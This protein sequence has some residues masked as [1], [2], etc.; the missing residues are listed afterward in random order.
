[1]LFLH[2]LAIPPNHILN[3]VTILVSI[4]CRGTKMVINILQRK[5]ILAF[6]FL[7]LSIAVKAQLTSPNPGTTGTNAFEFIKFA[8]DASIGEK[9]QVD[10]E[11]T[12][13]SNTL[14]DAQ[15]VII[16]FYIPIDKWVSVGFDYRGEKFHNSPEAMQAYQIPV[17]EGIASGDLNFY[18]IIRLLEETGKLPQISLKITVKTAIGDLRQT[19]RYTDSA[20]YEFSILASRDLFINEAALV[21]KLRFL[22]EVGFIAW[23]TAM[24]EQND[25]LK[26]S[27]VFNLDLGKFDLNLGALLYRGWQDP[28]VDSYVALKAEFLYTFSDKLTFSTVYRRGFTPS[29][30]KNYY[31]I[32]LRWF[33][34][35]PNPAVIES[36]FE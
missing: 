5:C 11:L 10:F 12:D 18:T 25:A 21:K 26:V 16:R 29:A 6:V 9:V 23:D 4:I 3:T 2:V 13:T 30:P 19:R 34:N 32:G 27:G 24:G 8:Q 22:F 17:E 28:K 36:Y 31:G 15:T 1:V 33:F 14:G 35:R 20:G 7:L